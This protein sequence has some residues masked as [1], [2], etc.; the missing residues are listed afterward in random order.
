MKYDSIGA[1]IQRCRKERGMT[2]DVLAKKIDRTESSVAKYERGVVE[3]PMSILEKI[4]TELSVPMNYLLGV[5]P[6]RDMDILESK[7]GLICLSLA[8]L[9]GID[10]FTG[11]RT[12]TADVPFLTFLNIVD[13]YLS[14][15]AS[16]SE[17]GVT[18]SFRAGLQRP[19]LETL[20]PTELKT[21]LFGDATVDDDVL[22]E[23]LRYARFTIDE[24]GKGNGDPK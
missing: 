6:F 8:Q 9:D 17:T 18:M 16:V 7:K 12:L 22:D 5:G 23:V 20:G 3:I 10:R 13:E 4:S 1:K 14:D 2:Q 21:A 15:I 11:G 19:E 24:K